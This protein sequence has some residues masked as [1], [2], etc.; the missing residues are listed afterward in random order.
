VGIHHE[1]FADRS[2][3]PHAHAD[4]HVSM[5]IRVVADP[6]NNLVDAFLLC[7]ETGRGIGRTYLIADQEYYPIEEI[8]RAVGRALEVDVKVRH[9]PVLPLVVG[10]RRREGPALAISPIFPRRVDWYRQNRLISAREAR[11]GLR[12]ENRPR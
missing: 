6:H 1:I 12:A 5:D 4:D 8:V 9:Y 2:D 3:D 7:M 11:A 10:A